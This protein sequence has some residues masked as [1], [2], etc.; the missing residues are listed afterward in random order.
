MQAVIEVADGDDA[1]FRVVL[2]VIQP[3]FRGV[4]IKVLNPVKR[5]LAILDVAGVF[6]GV[7]ADVHAGYCINNNLGYQA[8]LSPSPFLQPHAMKPK[9][10]ELKNAPI[11]VDKTA[12]L[13]GLL[14]ARRKRDTSYNREVKDFSGGLI[15]A[16]YQY[17][18][19]R[20][21]QVV[22]PTSVGVC[23]HKTIPLP[24]EAVVLITQVGMFLRES[25]LVHDSGC[26]TGE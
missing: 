11:P 2:A 9:F 20:V 16:E 24:G 10:N 13:R 15:E 8:S 18:D 4:E 12:D 17:S 6:V 21:Y 5:Q 23:F 7:I 26:Q 25:D 3:Q 1:L 22:F 19:Q 14:D